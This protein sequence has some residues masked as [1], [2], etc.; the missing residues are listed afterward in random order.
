[1]TKKKLVMKFFVKKTICDEFFLTK[2]NVAKKTKT[3]EVVTR[4]KN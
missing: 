4:L 1:M 2:S 3:T